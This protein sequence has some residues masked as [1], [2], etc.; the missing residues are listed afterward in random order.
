MQMSDGG[1]PF[2]YNRNQMI[3]K[4]AKYVIEIRCRLAMVSQIGKFYIPK[5]KRYL[6]TLFKR[7]IIELYEQKYYKLIKMF[8]TFDGRFS[9]TTDTLFFTP[10][11]DSYMCVSTLDS[12]K[13]VYQKKNYYV[14]L[15]Q[16]KIIILNQD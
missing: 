15:N 2:Y 5:L 4:F 9:L 16:K 3:V 7:Q 14:C 1:T 6:R 8:K 12:R 10:P 11:N 13:L